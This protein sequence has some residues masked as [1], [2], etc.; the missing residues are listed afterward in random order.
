MFTNCDQ[1]NTQSMLNVKHRDWCSCVWQ[2]F[3][4]KLSS[5][6]GQPPVASSTAPTWGLLHW[7]AGQQLTSSWLP[8]ALTSTIRWLSSLDFRLFT[9]S[10]IK[11]TMILKTMQSY[12]GVP[13][14][15]HNNCT[16]VI[17]HCC[18][19]SLLCCANERTM[20]SS[21]S[22][23]LQ[24]LDLSLRKWISCG[25]NPPNEMYLANE[26]VYKTHGANQNHLLYD[27]G[28]C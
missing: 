7:G 20:V 8:R 25:S 19:C 22:V 24:L 15:L 16:T 11:C 14:A 28:W 23:G 9:G 3:N 1:P 17:S 2:R 6:S 21:V 5:M 13:T 18:S 10:A 12:C 27:T 26:N 4:R